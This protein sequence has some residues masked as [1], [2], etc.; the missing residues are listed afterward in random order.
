M[1]AACRNSFPSKT[2]YLNTKRG[3]LRGIHAEPWDKYIH[4]PF[5]EVIAVDV[6][7]REDSPTFGQYEMF[8]LTSGTSLFVPQGFGNAYQV[9]SDWAA[10]SYLVTDHR[11]AGLVYPAIAFGDPDLNIPWPIG[12]KESVISEKDLKN[13]TLREYYPHKFNA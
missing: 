2:T 8:R 12:A 1:Q 3:T 6:D 11:Q 4:I 13:P 9:I 5:G 10:Y 7:L